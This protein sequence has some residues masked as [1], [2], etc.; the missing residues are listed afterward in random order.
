MEKKQCRR[1]RAQAVLACGRGRE[2]NGVY[3]KNFVRSIKKPAADGAGK[4]GVPIQG[5]GGE[6]PIPTQQPPL[7]IE[8]QKL[9]GTRREGIPPCVYY[10]PG[11]VLYIWKKDI[12][13]ICKEES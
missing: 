4:E 6:V 7:V 1:G 12:P 8:H 11:S 2:E 13:E 5:K 3:E 10:C 9:L